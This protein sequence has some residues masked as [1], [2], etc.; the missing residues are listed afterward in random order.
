MGSLRG[1]VWPNP[2]VKEAQ[3][4]WCLGI[5]QGV[6]SDINDAK[7]SGGV[8]TPPKGGKQTRKEGEV[9]PAV[10]AYLN[11]EASHEAE[12]QFSTIAGLPT[13]PTPPAQ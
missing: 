10:T 9:D 5:N 4:V 13:T 2:E 11:N 3:V 6:E 1:Q 7:A 12:N 8:T